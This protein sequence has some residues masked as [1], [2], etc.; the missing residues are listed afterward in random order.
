MIEGCRYDIGVSA[1]NDTESHGVV[2]FDLLATK[3]QKK[4][5]PHSTSKA[6]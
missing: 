2:F 3:I 4:Q 5:K 1:A 6:F